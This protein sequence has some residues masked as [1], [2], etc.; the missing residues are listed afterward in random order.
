VKADDVISAL[1][2]YLLRTSSQILK[3]EMKAVYGT[4]W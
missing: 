1:R 2:S 4:L 3:N